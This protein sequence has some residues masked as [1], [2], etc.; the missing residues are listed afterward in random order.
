MEE[1]ASADAEATTLLV[2]VEDMVEAEAD[3]VS[4]IRG[5]KMHPLICTGGGGGG[6]DRQGG[7][8]GKLRPGY[9]YDLRH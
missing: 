9:T 5:L 2:A 3:M 8:G 6:Y 7:G 4:A 1:V